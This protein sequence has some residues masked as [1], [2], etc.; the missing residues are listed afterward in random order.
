[1][2][3]ISVADITV[4]SISSIDVDRTLVRLPG[5]AVITLFG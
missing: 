1:M 3:Q 5:K 2:I 4:S